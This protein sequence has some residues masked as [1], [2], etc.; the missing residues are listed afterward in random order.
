MTTDSAAEEPESL[1]R[2]AGRGIGMGLLGNGITRIGSFATSLALARLLVPHDF[3]VYAVAL[4]AMQLVIHVNDVGLIAATI[5]WRG[6]LEDMAPTAATLAA[7]FSFLVYGVFW[8]VAPWF[9]NF[10]GVPE[11]TWVIRLYTATILIDGITA[12]R[13]AYLL[14]T[15]QQGRYVLANAAG[16]V[17]NAFVAIGLSL[18]GTGATAL[19]GGQLASA[20]ATGILVFVWARLPV[21]IGIDW[22][23]ARR[24][25]A[26][27]APLAV[28]L[29]VESVLEQSDKVIVGRMLG[30]GVLGF[31]LLAFSIS[32]WAPGIIGSAIRFVSLPG[33]ARL[34]ERDEDSLSQ[35]VAG[36]IALLFLAVMPIAGLIAVLAGPLILFLYGEKWLPAAAPLRFLMVLMI[37][38]MVTG[39][40]QDI[41]TSTGATHWTLVVNVGWL[42]VCAPALWLATR[43]DGAEGTAIAQGVVGVLVAFPLMAYALHK[44][45]VRIVP[46]A[47]KLIRP[48][49]AGV[50]AALVAL[51]LSHAV[52]GAGAFAQLAVGGTGG[53][54]V[55]LL[56]AVPRRDLREW[57]AALKRNR[58]RAPLEPATPELAAD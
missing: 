15:F 33:F 4:A 49:L 47:R 26:F 36:S 27:G 51:A 18:A 9:A 55:Y 3:G 5:Q 39:L 52:V 23:I 16:V 22:A 43:A 10:S 30:A 31:Y 1:G 58:N 19:A 13:S 12:V 44:V 11:A 50:L 45:G 37:V 57:L 48:T 8:F 7:S 54:L 41:L 53:M 46:L 17:V 28:S 25:L 40:C 29:A 21:R 34:S 24:L 2:K 6:R 32:S 42:V 38:R 35:G 20:V 14:R 56:T